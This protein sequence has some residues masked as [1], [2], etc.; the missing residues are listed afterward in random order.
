MAN[1]QKFEHFGKMDPQK[2][3]L[4]KNYPFGRRI[5][6]YSLYMSIFSLKISN[7][8]GI[9]SH[10]IFETFIWPNFNYCQDKIQTDDMTL[11]QANHSCSANNL[12]K[13]INNHNLV[14]S[15]EQLKL[16]SGSGEALTLIKVEYLQPVYFLKHL[17]FFVQYQKTNKQTNNTYYRGENN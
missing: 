2:N 15:C 7:F 13:M 16:K 10:T 6:V 9:F 11:F 14:S 5:P 3:L 8:R 4:G 12:M 1:I 17:R